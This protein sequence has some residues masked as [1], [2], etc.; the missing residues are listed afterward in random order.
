MGRVDTFRRA[1]DGPHFGCVGIGVGPANLSLAS[2]LHGRPEMNSLFIERRETFGWHDDQQIAGATLQVSLF[3]DLVTLADPTNKFSFLSYLHDRGMIYHF[4]N[5]QFDAM[6][7]REFRNYLEWASRKNENVTFGEEVR[8][9]EFDRVFVIRT[10]KRTLTADHVSLGIGNRPWVP[11]QARELLGE[12]QF[13]VSDF[14]RRSD[15]LGG[16]RVSVVGGGQSGAEAFLDLISRPA[17]ERPAH[18]S[19]ISRRDNF[20]PIDDSPFTND[21]F[22]PSFS[23]HFF[24]LDRAQREA[25]NER[26]LLASDGVSPS[27]LRDIY[28]RCYTRHFV[29]GDQGLA[30]LYPD[31]TVTEVN[32]GDG[33]W[34]LTLEPGDRPRAEERLTADVVVWATGFRPTRPDVLA[35]LAGRLEWEDEEIRVDQDFAVCW[36]GPPDHSI[37]VQNGVRRQRGLADPNL[38]LIAWRSRRILDRMLGVKTEDQCDSFLR[39]SGGPTVDEFPQGA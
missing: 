11:E 28:Q 9:V 39:W 33:A 30:A 7:R 24:S 29:E 37:F 31:R 16:R 10:S 20:F 5:A 27:T 18:V 6:P 34:E 17:G 36:D 19:W 38:S 23:D 3:K 12:S 26:Q 1:P 13:H 35:P 32:G 2:L 15:G 21:Y 22:T 14:L 25:F 8:S 4:V